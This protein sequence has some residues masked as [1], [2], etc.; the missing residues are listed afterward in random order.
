MVRIFM[1]KHVETC[2]TPCTHMCFILSGLKWEVG[3]RI[4][5]MRQKCLITHQVVFVQPVLSHQAFLPLGNA[6]IRGQMS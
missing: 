5:Q 3:S 4:S 2:S 6:E 1:N